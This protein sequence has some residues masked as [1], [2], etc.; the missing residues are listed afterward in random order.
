MHANGRL[1]YY[2]FGKDIG[3]ALLC[4]IF[5]IL[6]R[7]L[8]WN[9]QLLKQARIRSWE[10]WSARWSYRW[11]TSRKRLPRL[12]RTSEWMRRTYVMDLCPNTFWRVSSSIPLSMA[13]TANAWR[14][15]CGVTSPRS[16]ISCLWFQDW[17]AWH[18]IHLPERHIRGVFLFI[19]T[20]IFSI[21]SIAMGNNFTTYATP[22]FIRLPIS[23]V[24]P[25]ES[26]WIL[27]YVMAFKST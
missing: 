11:A 17:A 14:P 15:M 13:R 2:L 6:K 1:W 23:H 12:R 26:V 22:V 18:C 7:I 19:R 4:R 9:W 16:C 27:S 24:P 3:C 20:P 10:S 8:V 25:S 21:S 5:R